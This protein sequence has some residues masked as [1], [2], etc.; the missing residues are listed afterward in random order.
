[1]PWNVDEKCQFSEKAFSSFLPAVKSCFFFLSEFI[2]LLKEKGIYDQ[3][4][5]V[6]CSDH[7]GDVKGLA[8][9]HGMT[10]MVKPFFAN[11]TEFIMDKS[12]VQGIDLLPTLLYLARGK[13]ADYS[14]FEGAP[15]FDIPSKRERYIFFPYQHPDLPAFLYLDG[16]PMAYN[17]LRKHKYVENMPPEETFV[18]FIPLNSKA[19]I[20]NEVLFDYRP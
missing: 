5:I 16:K 3:T 11:N 13:E 1:M 12:G 20:D 6:V 19:E 14:D 2:H 7:G 18:Q 8:T 10:F 17:A 9:A 4:A 15:A